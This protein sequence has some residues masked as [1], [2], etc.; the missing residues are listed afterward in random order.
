MDEK[1]MKEVMGFQIFVD[2]VNRDTGGIAKLVTM[3]AKGSFKNYMAVFALQEGHVRKVSGVSDIPHGVFEVM[4]R[5]AAGILSEG[6][7]LPRGRREKNGSR[8]QARQEDASRGRI[9]DG[10]ADGYEVRA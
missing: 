1:T 3:R 10:G 9:A 6:R 2:R 7:G 8:A 5:W 4:R